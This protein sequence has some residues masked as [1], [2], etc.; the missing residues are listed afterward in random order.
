MNPFGKRVLRQRTP[1]PRAFDFFGNFGHTG[2]LLS[3]FIIAQQKS[4]AMICCI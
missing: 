1:G 3:A 2:F 4:H